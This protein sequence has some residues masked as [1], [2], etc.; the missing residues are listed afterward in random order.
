MTAF[1]V[2]VERPPEIAGVRLDEEVDDWCAFIY[3]ANLAWLPA[4]TVPCG[5]DE[6]GLPIG[7][8]LTGGPWRDADVLAAAE[9]WSRLPKGGA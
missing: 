1:P 3:P 4:V 6:A 7:L 2:G 5:V 8:Q 9:A